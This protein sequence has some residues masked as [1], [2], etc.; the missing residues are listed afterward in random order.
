MQL[1]GDVAMTF[2]SVIL[3]VHVA[4]ALALFMALGLE[5]TSLRHLQD[6]GTMEQIRA[7]GNV[8]T[9]VRS[10]SIFATLAILLPGGYLA[11]K[12]TS[13]S[14]PWIQISMGATLLIGAAASAVTGPRMRAI[15]SACAAGNGEVSA[16]LR[17]RLSDPFLWVSL[18]FR[19][20]L[21]LGIVFLMTTRPELEGALAVIG[22]ALAVGLVA[23]LIGRNRRAALTTTA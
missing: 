5:W 22:A 2:Y 1:R 19:V 4:G 13:W 23:S 11:A 20:A 9:V 16:A 6:S 17:V 12:M 21:A 14:Q 15:R 3:F 7:W 8:S 18:Q 10:L